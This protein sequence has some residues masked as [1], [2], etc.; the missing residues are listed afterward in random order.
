MNAPKVPGPA[1]GQAFVCRQCGHCCQGEGGIVLAPF[2]QERLSGHLELP[3]A[4]FQEVYT[5][6]DNGKSFLR[7]GPDGYCIF[8]QN[9]CN[10]HPARPDICRA[11]PYFRGNLIDP[12]S[13]ELIQDYCPGVNLKVGHSEFARQGL[14]YLREHGL[15]KCD[16]GSC[17]RALCLNEDDLRSMGEGN[18]E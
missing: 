14:A 11:W 4:V 7:T 18:K 13:W 3:M 16:D 17:A 9:G 8:Y 12:A 5:K 15:V 6:W 1:N 10:V 2:D